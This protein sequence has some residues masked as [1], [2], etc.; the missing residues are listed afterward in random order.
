MPDVLSLVQMGELTPDTLGW[1]AGCERWVPLRELP[2]LADFLQSQPEPAE[3]IPPPSPPREE[4]E[5]AS[6]AELPHGAI[7]VY[8]PSPTQRLLARLVDIALYMA[9]VFGVVYTREI[10]FMVEL[11]PSSPFV[12]IGYILLE[13]GLISLLGTTPGKSLLGIQVRCVGASPRI[14]IGRAFSRSCMVFVAGMGM[15]IS[16]LPLFTMGFCWWSLR[17]R[18]ITLW[19]ARCSTLPFQW[20]R[21]SFV[22]HFLA[23]G[24]ILVSLNITAQCML[25]WYPAMIQAVE[26][27]SPETAEWMRSMVPPDTHQPAPESEK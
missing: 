27:Q 15:M 19:D 9:L 7:R 18:G 11:L 22:R 1:H 25:P 14:G 2:A 20:A 3:E 23:V 4:A 16:I 5:E 13:S 12:W 17:S 26:Q 21:V 10:P 8:L 6:P 24:L